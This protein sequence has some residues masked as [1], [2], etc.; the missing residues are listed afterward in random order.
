MR[1]RA[2]DGRW[3][4]AALLGVVALCAS[5]ERSSGQTIYRRVAPDGSVSYTTTPTGEGYEPIHR[6]RAAAPQEDAAEPAQEPPLLRAAAAG[7]VEAVQKLLAEGADPN[8]TGLGGETAL[9]RA[10]FFDRRAVV[11]ALLAAGARVDQADADGR[12]A[13]HAAALAGKAGMIELLAAAG[14]RLDARAAYG[15]TPLHT[16]AVAGSA[17][18]VQA[19]LAAGARVDVKDEDGATALEMTTE[20]E[21]ALLLR[22]RGAHDARPRARPAALGAPGRAR[23]PTALPATGTE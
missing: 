1:R 11:R 4:V 23:R 6:S 21:V 20:Q 2:R 9:M 17:E 8:A 5:T 10:S 14:A 18:A 7:N 19:L 12:T 3:L 16:A 15:R 22:A 13:L